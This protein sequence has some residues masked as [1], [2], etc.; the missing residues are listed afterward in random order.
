MLFD[1]PNVQN[2]QAREDYIYQHIDEAYEI[3]RYDKAT[4]PIEPEIR[5]KEGWRNGNIKVS[6]EAPSDSESTHTWDVWLQL[7]VSTDP[8]LPAPGTWAEVEKVLVRI[9]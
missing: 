7:V 6:T 4:P 8:V 1:E 9:P 2:N 5:L 3:I